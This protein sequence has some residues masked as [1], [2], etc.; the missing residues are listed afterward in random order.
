MFESYTAYL[1]LQDLNPKNWY[2]EEGP[3]SVYHRTPT[4]PPQTHHT[5]Y[6]SQ[7]EPVLGQET[8]DLK[9]SY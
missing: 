8:I 2:T 1:P 4:T 3:S 9:S 7:A 5:L 6:R